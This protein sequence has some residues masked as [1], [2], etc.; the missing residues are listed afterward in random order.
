LSR[1]ILGIIWRPLTFICQRVAEL[2]ECDTGLT[3]GWTTPFGRRLVDGLEDATRHWLVVAI[4]AKFD[5]PEPE[6]NC[7]PAWAV[8]LL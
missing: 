7:F 1:R 4:A 2:L 5:T 6:G 3:T 8:A